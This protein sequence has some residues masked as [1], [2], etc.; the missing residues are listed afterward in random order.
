MTLLCTNGARCTLHS[1]IQ[2]TR[3]AIPQALH[4]CTDRSITPHVAIVFVDP[5]ITF[6]EVGVAVSSACASEVDCTRRASV[7]ED[8][9]CDVYLRLLFFGGGRGGCFQDAS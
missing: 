2:R 5:R 3:R 6:F 7:H 9:T 8:D 1:P 4:V